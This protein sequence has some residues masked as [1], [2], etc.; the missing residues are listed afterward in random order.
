VRPIDGQA[1]IT[2]S[3]TV[4]DELYYQIVKATT[5][6]TQLLCAREGCLDV[7]WRTA[8]VEAAAEPIEG[9][10]GKHQELR[11]RAARDVADLPE[12]DWEP[13]MKVGWRSSLDAWFAAT[14][15]CLADIEDL[16]KRSRSEA[17]LSVAGL[18]D[19]HAMDLDVHTASYRAGMT[20]AGLVSNWYEWLLERVREWPDPL[21][22][23]TQL[24]AME[25][26]DYRASVQQL[27]AY[28]A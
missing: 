10:A 22:R 26:Q 4:V 28:W 23:K 18:A 9:I 20:A 5:L 15:A 16:E 19:R 27:P 11:E 7:D 24:A 2:K 3:Q 25:Q 21:R 12:A 1:Q 6:L 17:G 14:K 8:V 13:D